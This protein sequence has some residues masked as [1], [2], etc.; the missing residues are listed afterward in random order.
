VQ[1]SCGYPASDPAPHDVVGDKPPPED[2][3]KSLKDL[4]ES[5]VSCGGGRRE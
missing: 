5:A 1:S 4:L 2:Q 3:G